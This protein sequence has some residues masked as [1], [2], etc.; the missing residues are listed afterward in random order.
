[1]DASTSLIMPNLSSLHLPQKRNSPSWHMLSS[2]AK[3]TNTYITGASIPEL[4]PN[5]SEKRK[6]YNT[7]FVCNP[8]GELLAIHRKTHLFNIDIPGKIKFIESDIRLTFYLA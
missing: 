4:G 2:A 5:T 3:E 1:M 8:E 6:H 7:A